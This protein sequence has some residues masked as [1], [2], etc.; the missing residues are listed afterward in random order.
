MVVMDP[1]TREVLALVG[2][3]DYHAGGFDR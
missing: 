1:I 2:G 3:Y